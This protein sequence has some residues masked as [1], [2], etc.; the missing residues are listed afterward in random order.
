MISSQ[1]NM[2]CKISRHQNTL[3][4]TSISVKGFPVLLLG[5]PLEMWPCA[6]CVSL[7]VCSEK[8]TQGASGLGVGPWGAHWP[9]VTCKLIN[10][11]LSVTVQLWLLPHCC[12][13]L[14]S[15]ALRRGLFVTW[16]GDQ[17]THTAPWPAKLSSVIG[18]PFCVESHW[19]DQSPGESLL[20]LVSATPLKNANKAISMSQHK[21]TL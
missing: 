21:S 13:A 10:M 9:P 3:D 17:I 8:E 19:V 11:P 16:V 4:K 6:N 12:P 18:S 2:F 1:I 14:F 15:H 20:L 5:R 7:C